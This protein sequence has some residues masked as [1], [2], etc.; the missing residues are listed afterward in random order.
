MILNHLN[1]LLADDDTDD[2]SFFEKAL[3]EIPIATNLTIVHDGEQLMSYLSRNSE[4]LPDVLYLDL[5]MPRKNG[6]ECLTEIKES[7]KFK[8]LV[9]I[10]FSTSFPQNMIYEDNMI[11]LLM[12]IGAHDYIRKSCDFALL[13]QVIHNT[14][15]TLAERTCLADKKIIL[16]PQAENGINIF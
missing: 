7:T 14:L 3:G 4:H 5:S 16:D 2:C 11:K 9:V 12:K 6:F 10:V 1:I 13:R 8:D 15:N